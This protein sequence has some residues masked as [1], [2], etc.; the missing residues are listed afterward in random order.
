MKILIIQT[1]FIGDLI[2]TTGFIRRVKELYPNSEISILVNYGTESILSEN[3]YVSEIIPFDKK[4]VKKNLFYFFS[5]LKDIRARKFEICF[6]PHFSHR[7]SII[8]F[9]SGAEI[10]IG[11]KQAGFSFLLTQKKSRPLRGMHEVQKL[12]LL[13]N[14]EN[15]P[16]KPEI[17]FSEKEIIRIQHNMLEQKLNSNFI[18]MAPSSIWE[19]KRMPEDKFRELVKMI[20]EKTNYTPVLIGSRNDINIS[21]EVKRGFENKV[22]DFTGKTNLKEFCY[23]I[24]KAKALISNDSS[25]IHVASAFDIPTVAIFGATIPDFGYTPLAS[26]QFISEIKHL[27][28]RPCGIHGGRFCPKK[29][30]RCM[31]DQDPKTIFQSL[32]TILE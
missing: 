26:K 25:P 1:A 4:K 28:C 21:N 32:L 29:H 5:F 7:S 24:S 13:L 19:T 3:P 8:A 27:D 17:F 6:S 30:F 18:V 16:Y 22:V 20:L 2:L 15:A 10:R 9:Y 14:E 31:K 11:Y 12:F 23:I